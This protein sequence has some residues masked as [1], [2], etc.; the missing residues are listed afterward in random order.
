MFSLKKTKKQ[1]AVSC[2]FI[3]CTFGICSISLGEWP[4]IPV[5]HLLERLWTTQETQ[6]SGSNACCACRLP[7]HERKSNSRPT[8][9]AGRC[10]SWQLSSLGLQGKIGVVGLRDFELRQNQEQYRSTWYCYSTPTTTYNVHETLSMW[11]TL[12]AIKT[13]WCGLIRKELKENHCLLESS[14]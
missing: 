4:C 8:Q 13:A 10:F 1:G 12:Q 3:Y 6:V 5:D 2:A 14:K 9:L 11:L 7:L